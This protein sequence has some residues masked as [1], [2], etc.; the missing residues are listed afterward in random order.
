V[1]V[2]PAVEDMR[3]VVDEVL[4]VDD[5]AILRAMRLLLHH[6]GLLVEPSGA[7]GVAAI[8]MHRQRFAGKLLA[9]PL[10]GGNVTREQFRHWFFEE[11]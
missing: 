2:P 5:A 4:L 11:G 8:L 7:V 9:T 10:C 3:A 1:P 6:T